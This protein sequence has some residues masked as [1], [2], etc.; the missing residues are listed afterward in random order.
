MKHYIYMIIRGGLAGDAAV[1]GIRELDRG[2]SIAMF[3][4]EPGL[5]MS[6]QI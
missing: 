2:G 1:R 5:W 3:S 4:M 6:T